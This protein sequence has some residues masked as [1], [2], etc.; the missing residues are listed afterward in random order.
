MKRLVVCCDGTWNSA[1]QQREGVPCPTNVVRL[2][3][4]IAKRHGSVPQ[5]IYYDQGVGTGNLI[6][7]V[8]GGAL[9]EGLEDNIHDAYRFLVANYEPDDELFF[10]G[11]S[12]GAFTARSIV[13]M[14]RKCGILRRDWVQQ[15]GAARELY[16]GPEHPDDTGPRDFRAKYS[17]TGTEPIRVKLIGVWDTVGALGIPL[18][19]LRGLTRRDYQFHDTELSATVERACHALAIDEHRAPFE[20]TLWAY[21]PKPGQT[22]EQVWFCG[23]HSDVGG[24]YPAPCLSDIPLA[25][26]LDRAHDAGL[27]LDRAAISAHPLTLQ[28]RA[29]LHD[30]KTGLYRLTPGIDRPIGLQS[31][32]PA[33]PDAAPGPDATQA[34]HPSVRERWDKDATYR[35]AALREYFKRTGDARGAE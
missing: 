30:S 17:L 9:G 8:S 7:R 13:G 12:R 22:V 25:W 34:V 1:D 11:F 6:D 31:R 27:E 29:P 5:V 32:D 20:P 23:A 2:A 15:Y 33:K 35:P 10:F 4:R 21:S 26:M 28:P 19:G 16:R 24:G 3:Y 18:R 14:L